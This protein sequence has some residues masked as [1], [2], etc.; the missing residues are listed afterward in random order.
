MEPKLQQALDFAGRLG[1]LGDLPGRELPRDGES[2]VARDLRLGIIARARQTYDA[3]R[4]HTALTWFEEFMGVARREPI[5][6]HLQHSGDIDSMQYNQET[7]D[8]FSE[9]V[10]RRGSKLR[11]RAGEEIKSDTIQT[12][13]SMI[14]KLRTHEAHHAIVGPEVNVIAP[15]S[16]RRRTSACDS[17]TAR[18][19]S[20]SS[21]SGCARATCAKSRFAASTASRNAA[22]RSGARR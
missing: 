20:A 12:Y 11:G 13:V 15:R 21:A 16:R 22:L 5:F 18:R 7:L 9:Y 8:M 4:L 1:L 6:M 19:A 10:R 14:K 3:G 2:A 17:S